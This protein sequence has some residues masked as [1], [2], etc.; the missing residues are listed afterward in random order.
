MKQV[1]PSPLNPIITIMLERDIAVTFEQDSHFREQNLF[2]KGG[3]IGQC[4]RW[5]DR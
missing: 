5:T 3:L 4:R 2:E 1:L